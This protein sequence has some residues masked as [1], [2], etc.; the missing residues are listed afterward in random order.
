MMGNNGICYTHIYKHTVADENEKRTLFINKHLL[1]QHA[2]CLILLLVFILFRVLP[3]SCR[4]STHFEASNVQCKYGS[5][6][7]L[8]N[9]QAERKI[10]TEINKHVQHTICVY[11]WKH[12]CMSLQFTFGKSAKFSFARAISFSSPRFRVQLTTSVKW[13]QTGI[14]ACF[15]QFC[16]GYKEL[17]NVMWYTF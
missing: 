8:D 9:D 6:E 3:V 4:C 5:S 7:K 1:C 13:T 2:I 15:P 17:Q 12:I 14:K 11:V 16:Q 10:H